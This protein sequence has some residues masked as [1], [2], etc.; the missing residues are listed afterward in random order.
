MFLKFLVKGRRNEDE[1]KS[2]TVPHIVSVIKKTRTAAGVYHRSDSVDVSYPA[3]SSDDAEEN[4]SNT[5]CEVHIELSTKSKLILKT[6]SFLN[7]AYR[8]EREEKIKLNKTHASNQKIV[9]SHFNFV[10]YI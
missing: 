3:K 8:K 5:P 2:I 9:F 10:I 1:S 6:A 4:G 7:I